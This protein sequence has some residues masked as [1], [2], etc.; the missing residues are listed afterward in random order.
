MNKLEAN[1][2]KSN[3]ETKA[4]DKFGECMVVS[5][6]D[7]LRLNLNNALVVEN[8]SINILEITKNLL[9]NLNRITN[10]A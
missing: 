8:N 1:Y 9:D 4:Q 6:S 10:L 5:T 7:I 3:D 2:K